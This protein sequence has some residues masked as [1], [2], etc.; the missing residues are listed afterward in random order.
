[1]DCSLLGS[2]VH[3]ILQV[4]LERGAIFF[5]RGIFPTQQ[6]NPSLLHCKQ[7]I[8]VLSHQG[9]LLTCIITFNSMRWYFHQP[10]FIGNEIKTWKGYLTY[11]KL[12]GVV[13]GR[14]RMASLHSQNKH[15]IPRWA[16][17]HDTMTLNETIEV[18][19]LLQLLYQDRRNQWKIF[20]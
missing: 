16:I 13:S 20:P 7:I 9:S 18:W 12:S 19:H 1:M 4:S 17:F 10:Y 11:L 5:S 15:A 8:K 6:S 3:W 14:T 2:S